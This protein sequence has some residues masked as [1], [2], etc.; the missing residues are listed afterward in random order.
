MGMPA[1]P[2]S[3][4]ATSSGIWPSSS[5]GEFT[6]WLSRLARMS[7]PPEP[8]NSMVLPSGSVKNDMFSMTPAT[9]C[10]VCTAMA[11]ARSATS[12]AAACG[13]VTTRISALGRSCAT[14]IAT[15][16][17]PGGRSRS[18]ISKSPKYTS[19]RNCSRARCNMGPRQATGW[20]PAT[21]MPM[22][23][24]FTLC[25]TGGRI[26]SSTRVG[27]CVMPI[28]PGTEKP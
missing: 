8:N 17:V 12:A 3:R 19:P 20:L 13:V 26:I 27:D 25:A 2:P 5:T 6:V 1:S 10:P 23:M 21:N 18:R 14:E 24:T 7:P 11:P 22:E 16:P 4:K 9:F 15:S 28:S